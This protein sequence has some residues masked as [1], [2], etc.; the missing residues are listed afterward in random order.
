MSVISPEH[1]KKMS[2]QQRLNLKRNSMRT[3]FMARVLAMHL[4]VTQTDESL[5]N[6]DVLKE[7]NKL[8]TSLRG[9]D[10]F[11]QDYKEPTMKWLSKPL[12]RN[13][14]FGVTEIIETFTQLE[15]E[16]D[17]EI[18]FELTS[19]FNRIISMSKKKK[20]F[21]AKKYELLLSLISKELEADE[22]GVKGRIDEHEG[23]LIFDFKISL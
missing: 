9:F 13:Q 6:K 5:I 19:I 23:N 20:K 11:M 21:N 4:D 2:G 17:E 3:A 14:A 12:E 16:Q 1:I 22:T 18:Y 7:Y 10:R 15:N 8:L